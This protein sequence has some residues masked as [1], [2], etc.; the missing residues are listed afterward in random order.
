MPTTPVP[1]PTTTR[2]EWLAALGV[3]ISSTALDSAQLAAAAND[4]LWQTDVF[5]AGQGGY[6]TYRIPA[7][8]RTTK[9]TL[10]AFC[11]GRKNN[12]RDHGDLDLVLRRSR[13]G[14]RT[15]SR[16][17]VVYEE[18]GAAEVTIGN[19]APVVDQDT[20]V[21]WLP[22]CRDNDRVLMTH[23]NDDG[24]TWT[25]PIDITDDVKEPDWTWYATG[26]GERYSASPAAAQGPLGHPM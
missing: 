10:L 12:R 22:F 8:V 1:A 17:Q 3:S 21:I 15:W 19:P 5:V 24:L 18:G 13:D 11:E 9:D 6:H 23:S 16:Q 4:D 7:L 20:G 25:P 14:G 26:T 2:R